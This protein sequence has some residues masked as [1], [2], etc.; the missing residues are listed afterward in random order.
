MPRLAL[1]RLPPEES[2]QAGSGRAAEERPGEEARW[3]LVPRAEGLFYCQAV[4]RPVDLRR[5][6]G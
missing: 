1:R 6:A 3:I 5:Y 2:R 4:G